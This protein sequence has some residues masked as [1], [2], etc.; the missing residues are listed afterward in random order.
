M[1]LNIQIGQFAGSPGYFERDHQW[2][3]DQ[4]MSSLAV[5]K[6]VAIEGGSV[7]LEFAAGNTVTLGEGLLRP[8]Q[9]CDIDNWLR[10]RAA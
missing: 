9:Q 1:T 2:V 5:G 7:T 10:M 6:I 4:T 3:V 8:V